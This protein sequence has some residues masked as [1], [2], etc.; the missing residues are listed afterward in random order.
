LKIAIGSLR[1]PKINAVESA[2]IRIQQSFQLPE[3][4]VEVIPKA[5]S[6]GISQMPLSLADL[7]QGS[8]NR[9]QSLID[10]FSRGSDKPDFYVGMEGGFFC[11]ADPQTTL[12]HFLQSWVFVSDGTS[13]FFGA[14]CAV[15]VPAK[16]VAE[17]VGQGRELGNIIDKYGKGRNIR[18]KGGAFGVLTNGIVERKEAFVQALINAMTPFFNRTVYMQK[19]KH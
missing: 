5:V 8:F 13:G 15:P 7:L 16:I 14:S 3:T 12:V 10:F 4:G 1:Q 6:S 18:D 2:V 9:A 17:V 19:C 11:Q